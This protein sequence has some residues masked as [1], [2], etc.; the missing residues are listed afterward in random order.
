M[1]KRRMLKSLRSGATRRE[2]GNN[3][4]ALDAAKL[5]RTAT[6][7]LATEHARW[8]NTMIWLGL[9]GKQITV[10]IEADQALREEWARY[11]RA[12]ERAFMVRMG[13]AK[14]RR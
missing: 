5:E 11:T 13:L 14:S 7:R 1:K 3:G 6:R 10:V 9:S 4:C 2:M 8:L 12:C